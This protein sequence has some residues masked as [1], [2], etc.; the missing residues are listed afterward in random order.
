MWERSCLRK[1]TH[2]DQL[3]AQF[4]LSQGGNVDLW[5][6]LGLGLDAAAAASSQSK[7]LACKQSG[8]A[9]NTL[10]ST[11][12]VLRCRTHTGQLSLSLSSY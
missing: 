6:S 1:D 7:L 3:C 4:L 9:F 11:L 5:F 2:L 10:L 12:Y 8:N